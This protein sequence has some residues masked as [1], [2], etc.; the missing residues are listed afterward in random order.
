VLHEEAAEE[1]PDRDG[2]ARDSGPCTDR[3]GTV[4]SPEGSLDQGERTWREQRG[5]DTLQH[6]E[7]RELDR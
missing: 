4:L 3:C 7:E 5:R 1:R 6:P 2:D